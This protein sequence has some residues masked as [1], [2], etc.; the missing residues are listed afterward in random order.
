MRRRSDA[1]AR[2]GGHRISSVLTDASPDSDSLLLE[3]L[4]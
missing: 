2:N 4:T 1:S 3:I